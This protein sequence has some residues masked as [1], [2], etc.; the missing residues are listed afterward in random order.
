MRYLQVSDSSK[1]PWR[2]GFKSMYQRC[3]ISR[4]VGPKLLVLNV[5]QEEIALQLHAS[6]GINAPRLIFL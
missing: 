3:L 6:L 2:L 1:Y 5:C 4:A